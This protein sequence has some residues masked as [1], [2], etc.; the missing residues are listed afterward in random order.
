ME[1][2]NEIYTLPEKR[3]L[4][5]YWGVEVVFK[6]LEWGQAGQSEEEKD[7]HPV[8][9]LWDHKGLLV[10]E[11]GYSLS[12]LETTKGLLQKIVDD[13]DY[14]EQPTQSCVKAIAVVDGA[15]TMLGVS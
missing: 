3:V 14:T 5:A 2:E 1:K 11:V 12:Q 6:G 8:L 15:I 7:G 9:M 10:R 4:I 13:P